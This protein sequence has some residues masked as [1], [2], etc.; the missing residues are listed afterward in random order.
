MH[1]ITDLAPD[2]LQERARVASQRAIDALTECSLLNLA[3]LTGDLQGVNAPVL[4]DEVDQFW[5]SFLTGA[6]HEATR[7]ILKG[8]NRVGRLSDADLAALTL[9]LPDSRDP[10][11]PEPKACPSPRCENARCEAGMVYDH[12][13]GGLDKC[14]VCNRD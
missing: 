13:Y 7:E 8:L 3:D 5:R 6:V 9:A 1:L 11:P 14:R 10:T 2:Y 12:F 4:A